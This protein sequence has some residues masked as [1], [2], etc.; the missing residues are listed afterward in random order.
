MACFGPLFFCPSCLWLSHNCSHTLTALHLKWSS[1]MTMY[2]PEVHIVW[3]CPFPVWQITCLLQQ[4]IYYNVWQLPCQ[5][6]IMARSTCI[7]EQ[8]PGG[9]R[10]NTVCSRRL[11]PVG[12]IRKAWCCP[13][14][15]SSDFRAVT[16]NGTH[17]G[18]Q[19]TSFELRRPPVQRFTWL[20]L[21]D[22]NPEKPSDHGEFF[23]H[24]KKQK[25]TAGG[26][27]ESCDINKS[28]F[29][30]EGAGPDLSLRRGPLPPKWPIL[31]WCM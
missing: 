27:R 13:Q 16:S 23:N 10:N 8:Y 6:I 7:S 30:L 3:N 22:S 19:K 11:Q 29:L 17:V 21:S 24:L 15:K 1:A 4:H 2:S 18:P 20:S 14:N 9:P 12:F 28:G 5:P 26:K 31:P 25:V